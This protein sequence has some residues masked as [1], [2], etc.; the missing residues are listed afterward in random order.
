VDRPFAP[1]VD[2]L[3]RATIAGTIRRTSNSTPNRN[4][5]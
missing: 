3:V 5:A 1:N 2:Y 4:L